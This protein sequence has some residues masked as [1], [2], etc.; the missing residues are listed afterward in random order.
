MPT[1]RTSEDDCK[2][3]ASSMRLSPELIAEGERVMNDMDA[4]FAPPNP[5]NDGDSDDDEPPTSRS[6]APPLSHL[7]LRDDGVVLLSLEDAADRD[8]S[9]RQVISFVV[10]TPEET[11]FARNEA[12]AAF[13]GCASVLIARLPKRAT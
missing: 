4:L 7:A 9:G 3:P 5:P 10:L 2:V 8:L 1:V 12:D 6:P 11:A 13:A